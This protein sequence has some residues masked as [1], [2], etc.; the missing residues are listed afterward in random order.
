MLCLITVLITMF[1]PSMG[2]QL[3]EPE[4]VS[5]MSLYEVMDSRRSIRS[6][7]VTDSITVEQLSNLLWSAQGVSHS[8]GL[9]TVPSAGATYPLNLYCLVSRVETLP[10]GLYRYEPDEHLLTPEFPGPDLIEDLAEACLGQNFIANAPVVLVISANYSRTTD[11]YGQKGIRY[12][13]ME[14]GHA[15]QNIYL[16]A[17][18]LGLGTCAVGAFNEAAL[19]DLLGLIEEETPLY[20]FPVGYPR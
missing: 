5:T 20:V 13:H 11:H 9:R 7:S 3:P 19:A 4:S 8:R 6:F 10:P 2:F 14:A 1:L 18:A 15:G 12:T 17:T 16:Q